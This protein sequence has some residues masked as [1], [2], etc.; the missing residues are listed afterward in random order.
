MPNERKDKRPELIATG[1]ATAMM[2]VPD[3]D[4][5]PVTVIATQAIRD[6][7]DAS[8]LQQAL[9]ARTAPGVTRLV[10]NPDAHPGYG[11]PI[12]CVLVSPTQVGAAEQLHGAG[13]PAQ[14]T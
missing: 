11:V 6:G 14:A 9:N 8:A 4:V 13:Q 2:P 5:S 1:E 12:G 10:L 3:S 7:F